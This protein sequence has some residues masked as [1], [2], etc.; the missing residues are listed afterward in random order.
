MYPMYMQY[1]HPLAFEGMEKRSQS[2]M[3]EYMSPSVECLRCKGYGGWHLKL[4]AYGAGKHFDSSCSQCNGWGYV[5]ADSPD[6]T[7]LHEVSELPQ[8]ECEKRGIKH[9]GMHCHVYECWKC[10]HVSMTD[11]SG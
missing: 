2:S 3:P 11:S 4:N 6:A 1:D 5:K 7:C 8:A 9:W 10:K